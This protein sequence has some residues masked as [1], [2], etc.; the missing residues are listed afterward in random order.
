MSLVLMAIVFVQLIYATTIRKIEQVNHD[1][2]GLQNKTE[3]DPGRVID[4]NNLPDIYLIVLDNYARD[5][6]LRRE[7]NYDNQ[8]FLKQLSDLGFVIP[9]CS[10]SNYAWTVLSMSSELNMNYLDTFYSEMDP[11]AKTI[12]Y[13]LFTD[14]IRHS[15][16]WE[17]LTSLGYKTI[18]FESE[19]LWVEIPDADIYYTSQTNGQVFQRILNPTE[20]GQRLSETTLLSMLPDAEA[21]LPNLKKKISDLEDFFTNLITSLKSLGQDPYRAKYNLIMR[22]LNYMESIA[23]VPGPK[24]VYLHL[25]APHTPQV[26]GPNGEFMPALRDPG[27]QHTI[28]YLN[29]R[30]IEIVGK[31]IKQSNVPPII[32]MQGDHCFSN[33]DDNRMNI[34]NAYYL[35]GEGKKQVYSSI[36][37]VNSFR[38]IL[39]TYFGWKY[40]ILKDMSNWGKEGYFFD[41]IIT[42]PNCSK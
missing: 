30:F 31:I 24:F 22:N 17:N 40:P 28:T 33:E 16:V 14:Y 3:F 38:I 34:F 19:F 35:P 36:T 13:D 18:S 20:F 8:P 4:R 42:P 5:D 21:I 15:L 6:V 23:T 11:K 12:N 2:T 25:P 10:M 27:Y 39:N 7:F 9:K 26:L 41:F 32:I 29:K 37:P 1:I